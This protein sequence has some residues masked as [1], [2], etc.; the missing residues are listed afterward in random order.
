MSSSLWNGLGQV[1]IG[2]DAETFHLVLGAGETR[3]D[4]DRRLHL[5]DAQGAQHLEPGHVREVQIEQNDVVVVEF[6]EIDAFFAKVGRID[7]ETLR[8]QHQLDRLSR[9]GIVLNQ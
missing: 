1:V 3:Q 9:G 2:S 7:V 8:L 4:Q 5:G 6:S